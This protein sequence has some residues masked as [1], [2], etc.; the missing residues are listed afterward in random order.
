MLRCTDGF[1]LLG[2]LMLLVGVLLYLNGSAQR[3]SWLFW[4]GGPFLWFAGFALLV[5]WMVA[6]WLPAGRGNTSSPRLRPK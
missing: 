6:R 2:F 3:L 5:G 1:G 4:L